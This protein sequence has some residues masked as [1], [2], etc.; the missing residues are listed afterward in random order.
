MTFHISNERTLLPLE[1]ATDGVLLLT[2]ATDGVLLADALVDDPDFG[3]GPCP[4]HLLHVDVIN[5]G[6][7]ECTIGGSE[8]R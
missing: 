2:L 3:G 8:G 7:L 6:A 1:L 5:V 4:L